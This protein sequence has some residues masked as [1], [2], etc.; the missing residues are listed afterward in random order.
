ML[1]GQARRGVLLTALIGTAYTWPQWTAVAGGFTIGHSGLRHCTFV[2]YHVKVSVR[3]GF[4]LQ[5]ESSKGQV[6]VRVLAR[7]SQTFSFA[8]RQ[9]RL[10]SALLVDVL[11]LDWGS[12]VDISMA[13]VGRIEIAS[14]RPE[15]D[16]FVGL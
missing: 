1:T 14:H 8:Q 6:G 13:L 4:A 3:Y 10:L 9:G 11:D 12:K 2:Y 15:M 5:I 16:L 7:Q